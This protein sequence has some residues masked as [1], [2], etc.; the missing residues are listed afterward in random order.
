MPNLLTKSKIAQLERAGVYYYDKIEPIFQREM[1]AYVMKKHRFHLLA[2]NDKSADLDIFVDSYFDFH[3]AYFAAI[4][5]IGTKELSFQNF[6]DSALGY[7][8]ESIYSLFSS[9]FR[10]VC[11]QFES[12]VN[13]HNFS[14]LKEALEKDFK[15]KIIYKLQKELMTMLRTEAQSYLNYSA[16]LQKNYEV[17]MLRG[18][19]SAIIKDDFKKLS[20][21]PIP[22]NK[23]N[24]PDLKTNM[25]LP[26][27]LKHF[28][29]ILQHAHE[30]EFSLPS[31]LLNRLD[32]KLEEELPSKVKQLLRR[33]RLH[34][35]GMD[36]DVFSEKL[37]MLVD[38]ET[39]VH[40]LYDIIILM[41]DS[42]WDDSKFMKRNFE[43][44]HDILQIKDNQS[45]S[46]SDIPELI[47]KLSHELEHYENAIDFKHWICDRFRLHQ[48]EPVSSQVMPFR[49]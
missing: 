41:I 11:A 27:S 40:L 20:K 33:Y 30:L 45:S 4:N 43:L 39:S 16:D 34:L 19:F 42:D 3:A 46:T 29:D 1:N 5:Q 15:R 22:K 36:L 38:N 17:I 18:Y 12:R 47:E 8:E 21:M 2:L 7:T 32:F 28:I 35:S 6:V 24:I 48:H 31:G 9:C 44:L 37:N 10:T 49:R 25:V 14:S 26:E 13:Y 23:I